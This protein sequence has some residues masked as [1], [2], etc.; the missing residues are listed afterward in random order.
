MHNLQAD[1]VIL[2]VMVDVKDNRYK[3]IS[4]G[5]SG[6]IYIIIYTMVNVI[7]VATDDINFVYETVAE[8]I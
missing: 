4:H 7:K 2:S 1:L 8:I 6:R 3:E 5:S